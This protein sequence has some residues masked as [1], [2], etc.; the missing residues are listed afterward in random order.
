VAGNHAAP[1]VLLKHDDQGT[2]LRIQR[3][4]LTFRTHGLTRHP[5]Q[6]GRLS[7]AEIRSAGRYADVMCW[8]RC[9]PLRPYGNRT[10]HVLVELVMKIVVPVLLLVVLILPARSSEHS[11][12]EVPASELLRRVVDNESKAEEQD[13]SHWLFQLH[14]RTPNGEEEVDA[15]VETKQG[16]LR[17][18]LRINGRELTAEEQQKADKQL[19]QLVHDPA[20]LRKSLNDK[21]QDASRS[22]RLLKM[23]P[24]AFRFSYG[25]RQGDLVQLN[26]SP[27]LQFRPPSREAQ[28]FHAMEGSIWVDGKQ[29]RV[30]EIRGRLMNLVKFGGGLLGHLDKGGTFEVK[31]AELRPGYWEW[32]VLNVQMKGKVL[33]FKTIGVQQNYSRSH[34]KQVPDN[35]TPAQAVEILRTQK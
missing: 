21:H 18:P 16:D 29:A 33:F 35:L 4:I 6:S 12:T 15:V 1:A 24:D 32:T 20:A 23:L 28:V 7:N 30:E 34:F 14:I 17:R 10:I 5:Y 31:Q 22:Q 25:E 27:N 9:L 3:Q 8:G 11:S 13:Q 2:S 19:Q 26:F